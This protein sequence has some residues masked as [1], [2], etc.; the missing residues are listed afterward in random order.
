M[1]EMLLTFH[2]ALHDVDAVA[3]AIRAISHAPIHVTDK[4]VRGWDF[5][6]ASTAEQVIGLLRRNALELIVDADAVETLVQVVTGAKRALPV[7]WHAVPVAV[8]GRIA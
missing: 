5:E 1:T 8:R 3:E 2:C 4:A 6:D 7:R